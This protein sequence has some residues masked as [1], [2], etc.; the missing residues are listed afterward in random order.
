MIDEIDSFLHNIKGN[1][2]CRVPR[3]VGVHCDSA[4]EEDSRNLVVHKDSLIGEPVENFCEC[5]TAVIIQTYVQLDVIHAV[6]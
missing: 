1:R 3:A 5:F 6:T 2:F 4:G